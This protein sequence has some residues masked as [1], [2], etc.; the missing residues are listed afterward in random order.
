MGYQPVA[1]KMAIYMIVCALL[2]DVDI[3]THDPKLMRAAV[4]EAVQ[5]AEALMGEDDFKLI[6]ECVVCGLCTRT[7]CRYLLPRTAF[8]D[9]QAVSGSGEQRI[10]HSPAA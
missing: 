4:E 6:Y 8:D 5:Q 9:A 10:L 1:V 3:T 7:M 2:S